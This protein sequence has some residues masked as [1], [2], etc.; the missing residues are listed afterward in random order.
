MLFGDSTKGSYDVLGGS[1]LGV[2]SK[3]YQNGLS[4]LTLERGTMGKCT[5]SAF[6][7]D[8]FT[9]TP[10]LTTA[11]IKFSTYMNCDLKS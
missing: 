2:P 5:L 11:F 8:G 6:I 7:L 3:S 10:D 4:I 1:Q 9:F